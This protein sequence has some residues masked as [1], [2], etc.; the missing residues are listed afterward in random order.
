MAKENGKKTGRG[1][2]RR[3][4]RDTV[5]LIPYLLPGAVITGAF[6]LALVTHWFWGSDSL[7]SAGVGGVSVLLTGVT[8]VTWR[9]RRHHHTAT[10]ATWFTGCVLGWLTVATAVGPA[11]PVMV[12]T[13]ALGGGALWIVWI[14]RHSSFAAPYENDVKEDRVDPLFGRIQALFGGKSVKIT[15]K[16]GRVEAEVQLD[17]SDARTA[18]DVQQQK[19]QVASVLG[20]GDDQITVS[21]VPG[22]ESRVTMAFTETLA[23]RKSVVWLGPSAPGRSIAHAPLRLGMRSDGK[24]LPLWIVGNDSPTDPRQLPHTIVTGVNGSGKTGTWITAIVEM[25]WRTDVVP[26]VAG[27]HGKTVQDFRHLF[28]ALGMVVIGKPDVL[29]FIRNLPDAIGYRQALFGEL[30]RSDGTIGY[31]QWEPEIYTLHGIPLL[32]IDLEEATDFLDDGDDDWDDAVR[33]ARS[34]GIALTCSLQTAIHSNISRKTR[35]QFTNSLCHGCVEDQDAKFSLSSGTREAGADPA[36]WRNNYAGS[37]Y[38]ETVGTPPETWAT[39]ARAFY[40]SREQVRNE[41]TASKEAGCWADIDAG[42]LSYLSRGLSAT[43]SEAETVQLT[44]PDSTSQESADPWTNEGVDVTQPIPPP[45]RG[46]EFRLAD[47][48]EGRGE[49]STEEF[50]RRIAERIDLLESQ[51]IMILNAADIAQIGLECGRK[52]STLYDELNRLCEVDR[53]VKDNGRPPYRIKARVQNGDRP[54]VRVG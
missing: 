29:Q 23:L 45:V 39:E 26:I 11:E 33:K 13:F 43:A 48:N 32:S 53:L 8:N 34:A 10:A 46:D 24:P 4:E 15:E 6:L 40:L 44:V 54:E 2:N 42:T 14:I 21:R 51:N 9:T 7:M 1:R 52:R 3:R 19:A 50:R 5:V 30:V 31:S 41:L 38:G 36:K 17:K 49:V 22:D 12:K 27:P 20:V 37:L 47:P 16:D 35:G 25:R 28:P 18:A